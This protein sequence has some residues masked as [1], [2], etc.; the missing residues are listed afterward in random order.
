MDFPNIFRTAFLENGRGPYLNLV[1]HVYTQWVSKWCLYISKNI[2]ELNEN[3]A[4]KRKKQ[5]EERFY[6]SLLPSR[7]CYHKQRL[8]EKKARF[9]HFR[10]ITTIVR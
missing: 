4:N 6:P 2:L 3:K 10:K 5:I 9:H 8:V 7:Y 1:Q